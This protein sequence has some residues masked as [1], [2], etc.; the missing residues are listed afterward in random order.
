MV[1][2]KLSGLIDCAWCYFAP[3]SLALSVCGGLA[4]AAALPR[5]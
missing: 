2:A 1:P 3:D 5:T 4:L